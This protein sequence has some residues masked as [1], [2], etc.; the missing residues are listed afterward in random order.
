MQ[1][2]RGPGGPIC[3]GQIKV[4]F[5]ECENSPALPQ[6]VATD[7]S[8]NQDQDEP[9]GLTVTS[10]QWHNSPPPRTVSPLEAW[11]VSWLLLLIHPC[12]HCRCFHNCP[13]RITEKS[14]GEIIYELPLTPPIN[15]HLFQERPADFKSSSNWNNYLSWSELYWQDLD[16]AVRHHYKFL[17]WP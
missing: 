14:D 12:C 8:I 15:K 13:P 10:Q 4:C 1:T 17:P 5:S 11:G 16:T 7:S 2:S 6:W 3:C 9:A